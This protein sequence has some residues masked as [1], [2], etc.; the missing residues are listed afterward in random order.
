VWSIGGRFTVQA[1]SAATE[2]RFAL[3]EMT[4][5]RSTEPPL[6]VHHHEDEA[7]YVLDGHLTV[8]VGDEAL[9]APAGTFVFAPRGLPHCFTVDVEPTRALALVSPAG[10]EHFVLELGEPAR[11]DTP[12]R[13]LAIPGPEVM[14]PFRARHGIEVLGPPHREAGRNPGGTSVPGP[15]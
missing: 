12:P 11:E 10:F 4:A 14:A 13:G 1:D 8:F 2:R 6:H 7:W 9:D 5:Y 15:R 3:L